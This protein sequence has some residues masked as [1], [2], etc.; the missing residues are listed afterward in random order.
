MGEYLKPIAPRG[1][2][3]RISDEEGH[4]DHHISMSDDSEE[5]RRGREIDENSPPARTDA[6][7]WDG[8]FCERIGQI[9]TLFRDQEMYN[10]YI[11]SERNA[12]DAQIMLERE[13]KR[14]RDRWE[15]LRQSFHAAFEEVLEDA[16]NL[17]HDLKHDEMEKQ[18]AALP[19]E[20][21]WITEPGG[22]AIKVAR[23]YVRTDPT[24]PR[25]HARIGRH[26]SV[27]QQAH[28]M[29]DHAGQEHRIEWLRLCRG[30]R[31]GEPDHQREA[32]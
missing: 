9:F 23:V 6:A 26:D 10:R 1:D 4:T 5:R 24:V 7:A 29:T 27:Q 30:K 21:T 25:I 31:P 12:L 11:Q 15:R 22:L 14:M 2:S 17:K 18:E 16:E 20:G 28:K 13:D 8:Y 32:A 19:F 3:L